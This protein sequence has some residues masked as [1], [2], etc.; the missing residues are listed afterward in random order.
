MQKLSKLK[1]ETSLGQ[2]IFIM[3]NFNRHRQIDIREG[4]MEFW[5]REDK[6]A[7]SD[8]K[9][10]VLFNIPVNNTG[11]IFLIKDDDN[12]LKFSHVL[13]GKGRTDVKTDVSSFSDKKLYHIAVTWSVKERKVALL[14]DGELK[15]EA[16][17]SYSVNG[18]Y[19]KE[20]KHI[21]NFLTR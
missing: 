14:V 20:P 21:L 15:E 13:I 19:R 6:V 4:A 2:F 11:S 16:P 3:F 12:Y 9:K 10:N 1:N 8:N 5:V 18:D 7:W 17:I